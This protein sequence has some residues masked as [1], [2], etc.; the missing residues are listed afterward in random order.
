MKP[1]RPPLDGPALLGVRGV[2]VV[3]PRDAGLGVVEHLGHGQPVDAVQATL[4]IHGQ[5]KTDDVAAAFLQSAP[6]ANLELCPLIADWS[7]ADVYR[8]IAEHEITLPHQYG[9]TPSASRSLECWSCTAL[10]NEGDRL[11]YT[12]EFYPELWAQLR[13]TLLAVHKA[14]RDTMDR[15]QRVLADALAAEQQAEADDKIAAHLRQ[16]PTGGGRGEPGKPA[17]GTLAPGAAT[18]TNRARTCTP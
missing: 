10:L 14:G 3:D 11:G 9:A 2:A 13:L 6:G 15:V 1:V 7:D 18:D 4:D 8:Y 17:T 16:R 5:R 12:R